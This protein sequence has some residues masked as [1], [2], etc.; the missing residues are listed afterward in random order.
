MVAAN[1][2]TAI[3]L[4]RCL[5][6]TGETQAE[7]PKIAAQV[8][9]AGQAS[10]QLQVQKIRAELDKVKGLKKRLLTVYLEG[11][12]PEDDYAPATADYSRQIAELERQLRDTI[13]LTAR[14]DD[15]VSFA[16]LQLSDL[17]NLWAIANDDQRRRV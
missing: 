2:R 6:P 4:L 14:A 5:S 16:Q 3:S 8:W 15:F 17:P 9:A 13:D 12:V 11:K 7:F 10:T 1:A